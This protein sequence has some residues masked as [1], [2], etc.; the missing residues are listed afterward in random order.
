MT[1]SPP[2]SSQ[3]LLQRAGKKDSA[4]AA[5]KSHCP[6]HPMPHRRVKEDHLCMVASR[7]DVVHQG[8]ITLGIVADSGQKTRTA[9]IETSGNSL[10]S[11]VLVGPKRASIERPSWQHIG[12]P[13]PR[14][15]CVS[16]CTLLDK[17]GA[18]SPTEPECPLHQKLL[19]DQNYASE[20]LPCLRA[21][22]CS[23]SRSR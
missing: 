2:C 7:H 8:C 23:G 9:E 11:A 16:T 10:H 20:P 12:P 4:D 17:G 22:G 6:S 5:F 15:A 3:R 19:L 13:E 1:H 21:W 18:A 14:E